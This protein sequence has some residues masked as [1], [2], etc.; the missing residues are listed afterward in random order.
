MPPIVTLDSKE[1]IFFERQLET[2]LAGLYDIQYPELKAR[3]VFPY[4]NEVSSGAKVY[5]YRQYDKVGLA[6]VISSYA[7]DF[8]RVD[9]MGQEFTAKVMSLG[10]SYGYNFQEI[11]EAQLARLNLENMRAMAARRALMELENRLAF[12]GDTSYGL[13]GFLADP[14]VPDGQVAA[15]GNLGSTLWVNKTPDQI[16]R[17]ISVAIQDMVDDTKGVE[18]PDTLLLPL[19]QD[20]LISTTPRSSTS[21]TTIK[22]YILANFGSVGLRNIVALPTEL[23]GTGTGGADQFILYRND[24]MKLRLMVPQDFETL[25]VIDKGGEYE[26]KCHQRFGGVVIFYPLSITKRYGI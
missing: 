1:K 8:N 26:I 21:D 24:P 22:Q 23:K 13:N 17:D 15:D 9:V 12:F 25:P 2:I 18:I 19:A 3:Q 5:T 20:T 11:R 14:N 10:D 7:N 4:S 16:I 6:K